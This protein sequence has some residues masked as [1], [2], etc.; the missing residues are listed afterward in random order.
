M[1]ILEKLVVAG[2]VMVASSAV[3]AGVVGKVGSNPY[4][5]GDVIE[6]SAKLVLSSGE[7]VVSVDAGSSVTVVTNPLTVS[8]KSGSACMS[9]GAGQ[10]IDVSDVTGNVASFNAENAASLAASL[11][12]GKLLYKEVSTCK[13]FAYA[14]SKPVLPAVVENEDGEK[15]IGIWPLLGFAGLA[16][17]LSHDDDDEDV[18]G[19]SASPIQ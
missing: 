6:G 8:L 17:I 4:I 11:E 1:G 2:T 14:N 7:G 5:A 10:T 16:A 15:R 12:N 19:P 18:A 3:S 9:V 13:A